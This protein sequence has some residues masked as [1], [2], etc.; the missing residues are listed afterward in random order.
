LIFLKST[1]PYPAFREGES[2]A[3]LKFIQIMKNNSYQFLPLIH[4]A[5]GTR[6]D[7]GCKKAKG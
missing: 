7:R 1:L 5:N 4:I 6:E 3:I 2:F